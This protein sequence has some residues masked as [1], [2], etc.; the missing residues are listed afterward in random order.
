MRALPSLTYTDIYNLSETDLAV[1]TQAIKDYAEGVDSE[2]VR[3]FKTVEEYQAW[4]AAKE[5]NK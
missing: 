3:E 4:K 1:L 5:A 2:G